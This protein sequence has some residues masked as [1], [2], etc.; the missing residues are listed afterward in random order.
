MLLNEQAHITPYRGMPVDVITTGGWLSTIS[1]EAVQLY[2][3]NNWTLTADAGEAIGTLVLAKLAIGK[4][5]NK[6][7]T[8]LATDADSSLTFTGTSLTTLVSSTPA[9]FEA[10]DG[11]SLEASLKQIA[12]NLT[13]GQYVVDYQKGIIYGK[14]AQITT[15][16]SATYSVGSSEASS[17][18]QTAIEVRP[19]TILTTSYVVWTVIGWAD[20]YD[21]LVVYTDFTKWSL[22]TAELKIEF[23]NDWTNYYQE[24]FS[25][26]VSG[27]DTMSVGQHVLGASGAYRYATPIKDK[28]IKISIK[29]TGTVTGSSAKITAILG[30]S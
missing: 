24:T 28:Y 18:K 3:F 7:G 8:A 9:T 15:T 30:N 16:L 6:L 20:I 19:A 12:D 1:S 11:K 4:I 23:S 5:K 27:T 25:A 29:W 14:K 2:Y 21:Q 17:I 10:V 22:T 13:D 26:I